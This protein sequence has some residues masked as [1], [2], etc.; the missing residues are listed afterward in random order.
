MAYIRKVVRKNKDGTVKV[1]YEEVE[2]I[3]I[4]KK[5]TQRHIRSLGT[6]PEAPNNYPLSN[7]YFGYIAMRL[8]QG[9]LTVNELI[10]MVEK[11]GYRVPI[12]DLAAMGIRYDF[13]K[14]DMKLSVYPVRKSG[15]Q[16][17]ARNVERNSRQKRHTRERS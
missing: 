10:E 13:K 3:R 1:Y 2:S 7:V 5:I 15:M 16:N 4:G 6:D 12:E 14:K 11:M 9:G 17:T 8:M